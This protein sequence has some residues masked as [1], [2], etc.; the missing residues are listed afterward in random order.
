MVS[1][2]PLALSIF[3]RSDDTAAR[4]EKT[5]KAHPEAAAA[6]SKEELLKAL[7][8]RRIDGAHLAYD[9]WMHWGYALLAAGVFW[10]YMILAFPLGR[11]T[12]K[13]L[14]ISGLFVGTI[15]ILMLLIVQVIA[16]WTRG[17]FIT[18]GSILVIFFYIAK[19]IAFSYQAALDPGNG[20]VLSLLGFTFGVGLC[21]EVC[22]AL[23]LFWHFGSQK[24]ITTEVLSDKTRGFLEQQGFTQ[25]VLELRGA[26]VWG[27]AGGIGF[28]V[29]EGIVYSS[30]FYNGVATGGI[31]VVRF[32]SCVALHA[33]WSAIAAVM[34]WRNQA[35]FRS[36]DRWY[37]W[38]VPTFK[39][40]GIS[41]V[42]HGLYD[43]FLKRDLE[44][45]ALL[46]ALASFAV[47]YW[48]YESNLKAVTGPETAR[49]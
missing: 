41:M 19:F 10:G 6:E 13:Q 1:L 11:S 45:G 21:E 9:T 30:D 7:P 28:G 20:F 24:P 12:S 14:W 42:L 43:T 38:F 25:Q 18:G 37:D 16:A 47:F 32:L 36:I 4:L 34:I 44:V 40:L 22:K 35:W 33:V 39:V 29:S 2:V 49:F 27:L 46:T 17:V 48:L 26:V 15:G 23:P 8:N 5:F 31:Y 3:G